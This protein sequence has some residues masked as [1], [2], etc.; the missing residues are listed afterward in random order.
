M[1]YRV[2]AQLK[3][4]FN[5]SISDLSGGRAVRLTELLLQVEVMLAVQATLSATVV[6]S[7]S[8]LAPPLPALHCMAAIT[9]VR[10]IS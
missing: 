5:I 10:P 2:A 8:C 3:I 1:V 9:A 4:D 6:L 7:L